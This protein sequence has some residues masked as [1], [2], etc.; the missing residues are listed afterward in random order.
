MQEEK[1]EHVDGRKGLGLGG[2]LPIGRSIGRARFV[3]PD[4]LFTFIRRLETSVISFHFWIWT[5]KA[6]NDLR[7]MNEGHWRGAGDF[8]SH[9]RSR[10]TQVCTW[11]PNPPIPPNLPYLS[12]SRLQSPPI[13][14]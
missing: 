8:P 6:Y 7:A 9:R 10:D 3:T 1:V 11:A 2:M 13:F 4:W 5:L 14:W 12:N